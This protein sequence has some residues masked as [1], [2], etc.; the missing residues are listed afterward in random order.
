MVNPMFLKKFLSPKTYSLKICGI[1]QEKEMLA[2][3]KLGIQA[4]GINFHPQS[5]RYVKKKQAEKLLRL[6][7]GE[8]LRIGIFVNSDI[9]I[10]HSLFQENLIDIA[11]L[12]GN[13]STNYCQKLKKQNHPFIKAIPAT[14]KETLKQAESYQATAILLDTPSKQHGGTGKS[15]DWKIA[16]EFRQKHPK[17][18][19]ILAGG[20][21]P[22]NALKALKKVQPIALDIASGAETSAGKKDLKKIHQLLEILKKANQNET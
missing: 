8:A 4:I 20:I 21:H 13:E 10:I 6:A 12:H 11:Q 2:I 9:E 22:E 19:L 17:I 14:E 18:P 16:S 5:P 15:F 1:T 7:Q 3:L